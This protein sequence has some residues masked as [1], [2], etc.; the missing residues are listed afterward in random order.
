M[1]LEEDDSIVLVLLAVDEGGAGRCETGHGAMRS[2]DDG[3]G[4]G[5]RLCEVVTV[6]VV[7]IVIAMLESGK[8]CCDGGVDNED[9][10]GRPGV[11]VSREL[12]KLS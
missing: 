8:E 11:G 3:D 10:E 4:G 1:T 5:V 6:T 12:L 7:V 9:E 2:T